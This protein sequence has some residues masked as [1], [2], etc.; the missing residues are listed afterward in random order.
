MWKKIED[1]DDAD[2]R[3]RGYIA[4]DPSQNCIEQKTYE[5]V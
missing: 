3:G 5:T 1:N 2:D 4:T